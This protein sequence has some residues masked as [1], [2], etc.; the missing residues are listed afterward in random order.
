MGG[1][2]LSPPHNMINWRKIKTDYIYQVTWKDPITYL[3]EPLGKPYAQRANV[4]KIVI[5]GNDINVLSAWFLDK[6]DKDLDYTKIPKSL[7][8]NVE[9][10]TNRRKNDNKHN[11]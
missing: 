7:V 1:D 5:L 10:I 2:K 9:L 11:R 4:G 3:D 6:D 8:L